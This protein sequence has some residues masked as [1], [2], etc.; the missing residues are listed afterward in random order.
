MS[1]REVAATTIQR[2]GDALVEL[3]HFVHAHPELGY[4][5]FESSAAVATLAEEAGFRV[6]S[7]RDPNQRG[8][9]VVI[10]VPNGYEITKE[11]GRRDYLVDYRPGAGIRVAPHFYSKD[12]ELELIIREIRSLATTS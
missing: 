6:N 4:V 10:D 8:G 2:H 11:L 3:S 1:A 7:P 12:E 9:T 5:E